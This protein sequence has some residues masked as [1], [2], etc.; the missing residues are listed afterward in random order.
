MILSWRALS[1]ALLGAVASWL[2][3]AASSAGVSP[4]CGRPTYVHAFHVETEWSKRVYRRSEKAKVVVTVTRPPHTDPVTGNPYEP[5]TSVPQEDVTVTTALLTDTFP[6]PFDRGITDADGKVFF[7][8]PLK[9]VKRGPQSARTYAEKWTNEG[10]C[11]DIVE[12]GE[13]TEP[14]AFKVK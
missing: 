3:P 7:E 2:A 8:I 4:H 1:I 10:G 11:P 6:P 13:K 14:E 5:P 9:E 12:W